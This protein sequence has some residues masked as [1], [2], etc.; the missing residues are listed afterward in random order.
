MSFEPI[1]TG[2]RLTERIRITAPR[3]LAAFTTREAVKAHRA[4][5]SGIRR[6]FECRSA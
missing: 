6:H 2:T 4:M 1:D 5:L 3:L